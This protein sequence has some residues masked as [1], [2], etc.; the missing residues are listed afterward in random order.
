MCMQCPKQSGSHCNLLLKIILVTIYSKLNLDSKFHAESCYS[1]PSY[2]IK[3][4]I[5][6]S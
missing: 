3:N 2:K 6:E 4:T 1:S 5:Y